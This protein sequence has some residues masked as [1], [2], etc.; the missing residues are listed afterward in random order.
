MG[1]NK[2]FAEIRFSSIIPGEINKALGIVRTKEFKI[3]SFSRNLK[4]LE[5]E[6]EV[7]IKEAILWEMAIV[8]GTPYAT[9]CFDILRD[10]KIIDKHYVPFKG[11]FEISFE[12]T[13]EDVLTVKECV[14]QSSKEIAKNIVKSIAYEMIHSDEFATM[15]K[16]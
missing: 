3:D 8:Q 12:S 1:T 2:V 10:S 11:R 4:D 15:I 16:N 7:K 14:N 6:L 5:A 13:E 9:M